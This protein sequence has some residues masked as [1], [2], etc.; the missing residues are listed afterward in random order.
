MSR[1][2]TYRATRW[3]DG[4]RSSNSKIFEEIYDYFAPE[5]YTH[6]LKL[7]KDSVLVEEIVQDVFIKIWQTRE[8]VDSSRNIKS[9]IYTIV[10]RQA[11]DAFRKVTRERKSSEELETQSQKHVYTA[12]D[13]LIYKEQNKW[14]EKAIASLPEKRKAIFILSKFENKSYKEIAEYLGISVSTVSNQLVQ[15]IKDI[16]AYM[17]TVYD[18]EKLFTLPL[19]IFLYFA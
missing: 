5:I 17:A 11:I 13:N 10:N 7:L 14:L 4:L 1:L 3:E 2:D 18:D 15:A 19:L 6:L 8:K 12:E 9:L 16:K